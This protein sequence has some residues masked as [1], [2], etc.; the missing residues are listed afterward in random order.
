MRAEIH[1]TYKND[2]FSAM[3]ARAFAIDEQTLFR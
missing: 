1:N 2:N 3:Y